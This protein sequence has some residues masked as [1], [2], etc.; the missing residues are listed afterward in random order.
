MELAETIDTINN[1]LIN[2]F[3]KDSVTGNPMWRVVWS[4]DQ[5]EKRLVDTTDEGLTLL[6][7]VVKEMPKY[8]QWI[9]EK[10]V[11]ERL[12]LVPDANS[13]ELLGL[14]ISY[15]P[16]WIFE[17]QDGR[18]LP[19]RVDVAKFVI[20]GIYAAQG[21]KS[22]RKYVD[23]EAKNPIEHRHMR[24]AKLQSELFGEDTVGPLEHGGGVSLSGP[25]LE[26]TASS[27]SPLIKEN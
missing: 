4:E 21:K 17:T 8:R 2:L 6:S 24:I 22:M 15:E 7:P 1:S 25:K 13:K 9:P 20:D 18:Y 3:G 10:Y 19:P 12:V 26:D 14:K 5:F 16:I 27:T 11:L 23:E